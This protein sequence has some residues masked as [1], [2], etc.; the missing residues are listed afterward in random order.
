MNK[1]IYATLM[2]LSTLSTAS[3]GCEPA[4]LDWEGF[5]KTYDS[6]KNNTFELNEF[7]KVTDF[8]PYP[9]PDDRQFQGKDKN[10]KLFKYLDENNDGKLTEDEFVKIYTLFPNP[11]AN[12]SHKPKWKFW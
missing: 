8:A 6:N 1:I 9:W 11:C 10:T 2:T 12:W 5:Y 4:S 7:L 3:F